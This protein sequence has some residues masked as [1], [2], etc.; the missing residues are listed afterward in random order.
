MT[1]TAAELSSRLQLAVEP[2]VPLPPLRRLPPCYGSLLP[3]TDSAC[4]LRPAVAPPRHPTAPERPD[5][6]LRR[7]REP[8]SR[9]PRAPS[10]PFPAREATRRPFRA[11]WKTPY[12]EA[13]KP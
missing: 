12:L 2:D 4:H 9:I 6:P 8:S 10:A 1:E 5:L 7:L 3:H 11:F 13:S